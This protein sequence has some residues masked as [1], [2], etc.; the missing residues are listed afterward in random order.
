MQQSWNLLEE[1]Y[2]QIMLAEVAVE[3][4]SENVRMQTANYKAGTSTLSELLD[5]QSIF[6][7]SRNRHTDACITYRA[8]LTKYLIDTGQ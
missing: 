7:Q 5:A 4:S 8:R 6:R 2:R 1:A 3:E